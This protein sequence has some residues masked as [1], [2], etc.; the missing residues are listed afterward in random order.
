MAT[1]TTTKT[2]EALKN[3]E[4]TGKIVDVAACPPEGW[5]LERKREYFDWSKAVIDQL[6]GT[7]AALEQLFDLAYEKKP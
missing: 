4:V 5:T 2:I 6:R 3:E 1:K 7:N